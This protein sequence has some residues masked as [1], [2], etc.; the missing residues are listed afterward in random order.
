MESKNYTVHKI[1]L[2]V[3]ELLYDAKERMEREHGVKI[4]FQSYLN[5]LLKDATDKEKAQQV[6]S[7]EYAKQQSEGA[8]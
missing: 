2:E 7:E 3:F 6:A 4:T 8:E 5:K 1:P